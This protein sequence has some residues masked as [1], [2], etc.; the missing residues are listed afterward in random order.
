MV[1]PFSRSRSILSSN[2]ATSTLPTTLVL[3][4]KRSARV[5]FPWS[6]CAMMQKLR[7]YSCFMFIL[8]CF[9]TTLFSGNCAKAAYSYPELAVFTFVNNLMPSPHPSVFSD[10]VLSNGFHRPQ[11]CRLVDLTPGMAAVT[12][13]QGLD[14]PVSSAKAK[15]QK[16]AQAFPDW[17]FPAEKDEDR[18]QPL[19]IFCRPVA[20]ATNP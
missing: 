7:I 4:R 15:V 9:T 12:S 17:P 16:L 3:S 1:M 14:V 5:D 8:S 18:V 2:C 19:G 10:G 20:E 11:S 13:L 6:M